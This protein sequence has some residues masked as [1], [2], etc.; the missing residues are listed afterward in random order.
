MSILRGILLVLLPLVACA[1]DADSGKPPAKK[2]PEY[3]RCADPRPEICTQHYQPV[4]ALRD[5][6][7]RCIKAPCPSAS[8]VPYPNACTA[9]NDRHVLGYRPGNCPAKFPKTSPEP[10]KKK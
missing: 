3:V 9:C 1:S 6:G 7:V 4:C 10:G 5:T 2:P 8:W